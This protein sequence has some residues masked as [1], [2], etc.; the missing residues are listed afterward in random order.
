MGT[1]NLPDPV[2]SMTPKKKLVGV[3]PK[4]PEY[5]LLPGDSLYKRADGTWGKIGPGLGIE[6]FV[7]NED[8]LEPWTREIYNRELGP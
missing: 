6:G 2:D 1:I 5:P 4:H 7:L 3:H 8:D